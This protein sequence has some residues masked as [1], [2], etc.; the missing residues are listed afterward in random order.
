MLHG[1]LDS[2][3]I[4]M[5]EPSEMKRS[6][7]H[8]EAPIYAFLSETLKARWKRY[9]KRLK[10]C[11]RKFS[12]EAVHDSRIET[13]RLLSLME[14]LGWFLRS[15]QLNKAR[16]ILKH[17][18]DTFDELRD[19]HVQLIFVGRMLRAFP[20]MHA[21]HSALLRR[22]SR[23][24]SQTAK[25]IKEVK[26]TRL[27]RSIRSLRAMLDEIDE[28][29]SGRVHGLDHA[30]RAIDRAYAGVVQRNRRVKPT[31]T[32]TI[33]RTRVAFKKFRYMVELLAPLLPGVSADRINTMQEYQA[34]MGDIQDSE[35]LLAA[36]DKFL[37]KGKINPGGG[38]RFREELLRQRQWLIEFYLNETDRL[39]EFWPL[40]PQKIEKRPPRTK[41]KAK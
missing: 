29:P 9:C 40:K 32:T 21:F 35:V 19:I 38:Q 25:D 37:R 11:Q 4:T 3:F 10:Q 17:H 14:L 41:Q 15:G 12:E 16:R 39:H 7:Q 22:E 36:F 34:M 28:T 31:D 33:H 2:L 8:A 26:T 13:R 5:A 6:E 30:I 23:C 24:A 20:A 18:L 27:E 1:F